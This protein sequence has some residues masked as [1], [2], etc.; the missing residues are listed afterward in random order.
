[1]VGRRGGKE[2]R[3]IVGGGGIAAILGKDDKKIHE[4]GE[5]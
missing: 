4:D 5:G 1:M 2:G 3:G